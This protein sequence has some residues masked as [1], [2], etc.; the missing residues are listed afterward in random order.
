MS[1]FTDIR[2]AIMAIADVRDIPGSVGLRTPGEKVE[3]RGQEL[4]TGSAWGDAK[5][6]Q[7]LVEG[8]ATWMD[9]A[10]VGNIGAIYSKLNELIGQYNQLREDYIA[11]GGTTTATEVTPL[12]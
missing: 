1:T 5:S 2:D 12:P 11:G 6:L 8:I 9:G 4:D 3:Y 7:I 10:G